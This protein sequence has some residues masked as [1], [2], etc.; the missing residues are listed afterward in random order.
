MR[1]ERIANSAKL[2][3]I[4]SGTAF[5]AKSFQSFRIRGKRH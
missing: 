5:A 2:A 3:R 1:S 4:G